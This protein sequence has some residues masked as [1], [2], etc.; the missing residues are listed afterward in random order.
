MARHGSRSHG[1]HGALVVHQ[2]PCCSAALLAWFSFPGLEWQLSQAAGDEPDGLRYKDHGHG[3]C[4]TRPDRTPH[5]QDDGTDGVQWGAHGVYHVIENH[6]DDTGR[7]VGERTGIYTGLSP[8]T[9]RWQ[10]I[11]VLFRGLRDCQVKVPALQEGLSWLLSWLEIPGDMAGFA[12]SIPLVW[13]LRSGPPPADAVPGSSSS[14]GRG[15]AQPASARPVFRCSEM[16]NAWTGTS[17]RWRWVIQARI[18]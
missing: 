12:W 15:R 3:E 5:V 4:N 14:Q 17:R 7:G 9:A 8:R 10:R 18:G 16:G 13:R 2:Q 1:F 11:P 6:D